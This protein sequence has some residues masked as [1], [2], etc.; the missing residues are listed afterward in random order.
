MK[1]IKIITIICQKCTKNYKKLLLLGGNQR[2]AGSSI[3]DI[4]R[5]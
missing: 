2:K 1:N 5:E 3:L 4:E